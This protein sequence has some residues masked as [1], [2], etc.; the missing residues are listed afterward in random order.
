MINHASLT[1]LLQITQQTQRCWEYQI[2]SVLKTFPFAYTEST[3]FVPLCRQ[4]DKP[5]LDKWLVCLWCCCRLVKQLASSDTNWWHVG[6][7]LWQ[8]RLK[9]LYS[10]SATI[11]LS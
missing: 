10:A 1:T 6:R 4:V 3:H 9:S 11:Y 2:A 7:A 8:L 5:T